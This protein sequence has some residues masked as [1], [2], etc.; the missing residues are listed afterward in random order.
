M[1]VLINNYVLRE[2]IREGEMGSGEEWSD[3]G[4]D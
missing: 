4:G 1:K 2:V 3:G